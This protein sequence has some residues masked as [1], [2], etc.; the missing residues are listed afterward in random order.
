MTGRWPSRDPIEEQGGVN[1]YGFVRNSPINNFD[2]LGKFGYLDYALLADYTTILRY[3]NRPDRETPKAYDDLMGELKGGTS[4]E[5][6][7]VLRNVLKDDYLPA[8]PGIYRFEDGFTEMMHASIW[9]SRAF[10]SG[11]AI[12]GATSSDDVMFKLKGEVCVKME[13]GRKVAIAKDVSGSAIWHDEM[14]ANNY[15][16]SKTKPG[17]PYWWEVILGDL[18]GDKILDL[19]FDFSVT[20]EY[21]GPKTMKVSE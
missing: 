9:Y 13:N 5:F 1:L 16:E 3:S 7:I 6:A 11:L 14:D 15:K 20:F 12:V 18:V 17:G 10:E 2:V 21:G 8:N 4:D 19:E